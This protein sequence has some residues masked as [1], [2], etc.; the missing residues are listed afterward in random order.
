MEPSPNECPSSSKS[1]TNRVVA[2][3]S[4]WVTTAVVI[5]LLWIGTLDPLGGLPWTHPFNI[6]LLMLCI[7]WAFGFTAMIW[8]WHKR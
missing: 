6:V 7:G 1:G 3:V 5:G 2:T 8:G 4:A